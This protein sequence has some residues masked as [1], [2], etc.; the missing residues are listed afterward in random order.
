MEFVSSS[1]VT[2]ISDVDLP[3]GTST[4]TLMPVTLMALPAALRS[5]NE[6]PSVVAIGL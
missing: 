4:V 6:N 5:L 3:E 1:H 2:G